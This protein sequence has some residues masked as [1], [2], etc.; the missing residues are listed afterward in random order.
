MTDIVMIIPEITKGMKSF[1]PKALITIRGK[2]LIEHQI[3]ILRS[4]YKNNHIYLLTG[5]ESDRIKK[6]ILTSKIISPKNISILE[7][8][9]YD[10]SGQMTSVVSYIRQKENNNGAIFINNGIITK[11]NFAKNFNKSNNSI[12]LI[13]GKKNNFNIGCADQN[14]I[15]YLFYDLPVLWSECIY[16]NNETMSIV[17]DMLLPHEL[18]TL[19]F[20][21]LVNK[22]LE[23]SV[24]FDKVMIPKTQITKI[25][26]IKDINKAKIFI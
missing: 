8:K 2:T 7:N 18:K 23:R 26:H 4:V 1:G 20:F 10:T 15:E 6:T 19:F 9:Q 16:L 12:F 21:E 3:S 25:N 11:F 22:L 14:S 13:K 5:F 17:K 24:S